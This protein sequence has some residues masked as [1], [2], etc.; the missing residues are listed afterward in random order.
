MGNCFRSFYVDHLQW[1]DFF[2]FK[3]KK[4]KGPRSMSGISEDSKCACSQSVL[5]NVSRLA[6]IFSGLYTYGAR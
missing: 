4:K 2:F 6:F 3:K 5:M 1:S